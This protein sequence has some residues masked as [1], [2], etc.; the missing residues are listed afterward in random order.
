MQ[1]LHYDK[2][3]PTGIESL[4]LRSF[5]GKKMSGAELSNTIPA[6]KG[7]HTYLQRMLK[8]GLIVRLG[9]GVE[10]HK[11]VVFYSITELGQQFV[12]HMNVGTFI[13]VMRRVH[14]DY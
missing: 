10:N 14:D 4:I 13:P 2:N 6:T 5:Q 11:G 1:G 12:D 3:S 8:K 7:L 9:K